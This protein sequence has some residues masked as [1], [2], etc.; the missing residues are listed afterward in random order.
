MAC[1]RIWPRNPEHTERFTTYPSFLTM[2]RR[3]TE[4]PRFGQILMT[5]NLE[6]VYMEQVTNLVVK[7]MIK[8]R[9]ERKTKT[10]MDDLGKVN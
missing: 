7:K 10:G 8:P 1:H 5:V 2:Q 4:L 3:H 9:Q 6:T